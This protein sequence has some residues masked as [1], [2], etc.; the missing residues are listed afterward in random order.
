MLASQKSELLSA[1]LDRELSGEELVYVHEQLM[2]SA[3]WREEL[4]T[5]KQSK[6]LLDTLPHISAPVDLIDSLVSQAEQEQAIANK[7]LNFNWRW[8]FSFNPWVMGGSFAT[9][10]AAALLVFHLATP[11]AIE[12]M[13]L[14]PFLAAYNQAPASTYIQ[15]QVLSASD[16]SSQLKRHAN[17][18]S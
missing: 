9:A 17:P 2:N 12:T 6:A 11:R 8:T 1:F 15:Q 16:Y 13:P 18:N 4:E 7:K 10:A 14:E 3:E 5:L